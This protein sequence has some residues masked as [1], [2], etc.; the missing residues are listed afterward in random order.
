MDS[1]QQ[2]RAFAQELGGKLP[3]AYEEAFVWLYKTLA[4]L[5]LSDEQRSELVE[6]Y[7]MVDV[8]RLREVNAEVRKAGIRWTESI[9]GWPNRYFVFGDDGCGGYY[10]VDIS[11]SSLEECVGY[12]EHETP[13]F[14]NTGDTPL[15]Y[16]KDC[17]EVVKED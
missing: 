7:F 11:D 2:V 10:Y 1:V 12:Y 14:E 8:D 4:T 16:L 17:V 6:V 3:Q 9:V 15:E 5:D 13:E